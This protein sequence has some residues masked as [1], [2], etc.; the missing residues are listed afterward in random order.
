MEEFRYRLLDLDLQN[1]LPTIIFASGE[2]G[3]G[4]ILRWRRRLVG[5]VLEERR[6]RARMTAE[7]VARLVS[8][9]AAVRVLEN[10]LREKLSP[11][12]AT[13]VMPSVSVAICTRNRPESLDRCLASLR[14]LNP[15]PLALVAGFEVLVIDNAPPDDRTRR[16]AEAAPGVRYVM[17]PKAGLNFGRNRALQEAQGNFLAFVDDDVVVDQGWLAGLHEAWSENPDAKGFTG[18]V[19]PL[20]L[21]TEAQVLFERRGGFRRGLDKIRYQG[22]RLDNPLFPCGAGIF[23]AGANM[24]FDRA[25]LLAIGGFDDALDTG[26]PLPGG[27]DLDIFYRVARTGFPFIYE[28]QFAVFHEHRRDMAG[29][30]RQYWTWGLAHM[31]FVVKSQ[32]VD[33]PYRARFRRLILWWFRDQFRQLVRSILG[34]HVLPPGMIAAELFGGIVGLCGEYGRS[35]RRVE[36][37]RKAAA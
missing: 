8:T 36:R 21:G 9:D 6:G 29:L 4:L 23:G 7:E 18:L 31:A 26:A 32:V 11:E 3:V 27:G 24:A 10:R 35:R 15:T 20:A 14:A 22:A 16:V 5:Y 19:L 12:G 28:P 25:T 37:I 17:E 30:K 13:V 33:K 34:R 1:P 2:V